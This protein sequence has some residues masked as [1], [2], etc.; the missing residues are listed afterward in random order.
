MS[1]YNVINSILFKRPVG[2]EIIEEFHVPFMFN[3]WLSFYDPVVV[4]IANEFN[5]YLGLFPDKQLS[6]SFLY[7]VLPQLKYQKINYIK[8]EKKG[9]ETAKAQRE[10]EEREQKIKA[11]AHNL[12]ISEREAKMYIDMLK[13]IV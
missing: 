2:T 3:R 7:T 5:K 1:V 11:I 12:E 4:P 8:K 6:Y 10:R 9:T 13:G